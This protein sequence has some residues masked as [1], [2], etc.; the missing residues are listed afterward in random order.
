MRPIEEYIIEV[1]KRKKITSN[2]RLAHTLD[3]SQSV[4]CYV[5]KGV[6]TPSDTVC[7]KLSDLSGDPLEKVLLL[8]AESRAP[9]CS[10]AAWHNLFKASGYAI[11]IFLTVALLT[12]S[13]PSEA[14][15]NPTITPDIRVDWILCQIG[16]GAA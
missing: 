9:E 3:I 10:K 5:M 11:S 12:A 7:K 15:S 1:K 6:T 14:H 4:L 2:A 13:L 16:Y 8:A